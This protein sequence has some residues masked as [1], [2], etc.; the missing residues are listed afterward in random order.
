MNVRIL[1]FMLGAVLF[2]L[3][4]LGL[5]FI[6]LALAYAFLLAPHIPAGYAPYGFIPLF[7]VSGFVS[8][9]LYK[10]VLKLLPPPADQ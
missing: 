10:L 8:C 3:I 2:N 6:P 4:V 1:L 9:I 5:C 7:A